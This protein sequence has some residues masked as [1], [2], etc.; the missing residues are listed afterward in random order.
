VSILILSF[1]FL[2]AFCDRSDSNNFLKIESRWFTASEF[3]STTPKHTFRYLPEE[4][5]NKIIVGFIDRQMFVYKG[6]DEGLLKNPDIVRNIRLSR[7]RLL[8]NEYFDRMVLDS[9][10]TKQSLLAE[11]ELLNPDKKD[12][13]TFDEYKPVIKKQLI[14]KFSNDIQLKYYE[15]V[16]SIKADYEFELIRPNIAALSKVYMDS[17]ISFKTD[18]IKKSSTDILKL[19]G[20]SLPLYCTKGKNVFLDD[21]LNLKNVYPFVLPDQFSDPQFLA[22]VIE[23]VAI[24]NIVLNVSKKMRLDKTS[25]FK[26]RMATRQNTLLYNRVFSDEITHKITINDD[27]LYQFYL[28]KL[29]SLYLSRSQYEVQEIFINDKELAENVLNRALHQVNF[30]Q[31][32]YKY[33]ERYRN[34]PLKGYLGYIHADLYA[35][36]GRSAAITEAG[37]VCPNLVSSGKGFSIIK[38]L[39]VI[40]PKPIPFFEIKGK[41]L[42]DYKRT[43]ITRLKEE[44]LRSLRHKYTY[45]INYSSLSK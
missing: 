7:H 2:V 21:F 6:I 37:S 12:L 29:D 10:V 19:T 14:N 41:I 9:I 27:T 28:I 39:S 42:R 8:I 45:D 1:L 33:T 18:S 43:T 13:F 30:N 35:D 22:N 15:T 11:Y 17:L 24:N 26:D 4:E 25:G 32:A 36:I 16:E 3:Y 23:S 31:L 38:V 34:K 20:F 44:L 5:K 40:N